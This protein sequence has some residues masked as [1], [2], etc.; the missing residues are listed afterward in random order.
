MHGAGYALVGKINDYPIRL[1][2]S[3]AAIKEFE[4]ATFIRL[5]DGCSFVHEPLLHARLR[6]DAN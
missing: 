2:C 5:M 4:Q 3:K 1:D 6:V